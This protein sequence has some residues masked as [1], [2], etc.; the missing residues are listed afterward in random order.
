M[1]QAERSR[2]TPCRVRGDAI[3]VYAGSL[4]LGIQGV[5]GREVRPYRRVLQAQAFAPR[6]VVG[7]P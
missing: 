5:L 4:G 6:E 3:P 7:L 1:A 2:P